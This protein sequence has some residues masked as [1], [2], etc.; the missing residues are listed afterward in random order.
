MKIHYFQ[1]YNQK[2]NVATANTMLLLSRLYQ[3]SPD[4]FFQFLRQ[5]LFSNDFDPALEIHMQK[6]GGKTI[7]DAYLS[8]PSFSIVVEAKAQGSMK[9]YNTFDM[10]Q[11]KG[12]LEHFKN[13]DMQ[14]LLTLASTPMSP[15]QKQELMEIIKTYNKEHGTAIEHVDMTFSQILDA[16]REYSDDRD[17]QMNDVIEDFEGYLRSSDL[18]PEADAWKTMRMQLAGATIDFN[19][20]ESIYYDRASRGFRPHD[21]LAL[22]NDKR[23]KALGKLIAIINADMIDGDFHYS[24]QKGE[25]N[26]EKINK[27]KLCM[28]DADRRGWDLR[29]MEHTY[30]F[31]DG[32]YR[33]DFRKSTKR[34]PMGTRVFDLESYIEGFDNTFSAEDIAKALDGKTWE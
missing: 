25:I 10:E 19:I 12:H 22:Y 18:I 17:Y 20:A 14:V 16:V 26:D 30:F 32:F 1:R 24:V 7:P 34:P 31:T 29:S 15:E 3:S 8:Q 11:L 28:D 2:E 21:Y 5:V 27:I 9:K 4:A 23:V 33:T 13:E 6:T